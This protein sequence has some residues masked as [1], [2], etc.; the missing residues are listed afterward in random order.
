MMTRFRTWLSQCNCAPRPRADAAATLT[1]DARLDSA[2]FGPA[3]LQHVVA[4]FTF[5]G[6][7][8]SLRQGRTLVSI[9][10]YNLSTPECIRGT[11]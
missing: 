11:S 3:F 9:S 2:Q 1:V 7:G 10:A 6:P 4:E 5:Y 8:G